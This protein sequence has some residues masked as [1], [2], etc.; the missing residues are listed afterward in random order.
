[1]PA[2]VQPVVRIQAEDF[3]IA[4]EISRLTRG[5]AD[6]GAVVTFSGL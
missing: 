6:V 3:D 1:M 4:T 2:E 5:R